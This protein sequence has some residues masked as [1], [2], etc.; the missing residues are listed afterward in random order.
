MLGK[1]A[2]DKLESDEENGEKWP[3]SGSHDSPFRVC[4]IAYKV[5][6]IITMHECMCV[7]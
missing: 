1:S 2:R 3:V 4:S 7:C 6:L 5:Q